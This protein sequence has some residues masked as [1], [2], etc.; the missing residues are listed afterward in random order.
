VA[1][2]MIGIGHGLNVDAADLLVLYKPAGLL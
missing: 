2:P 1:I